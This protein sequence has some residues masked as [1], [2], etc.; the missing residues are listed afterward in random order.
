MDRGAWQATVH[1]VVKSNTT[2]QLRLREHYLNPSQIIALLWRRGLHD[3]HRQ[4]HC[5]DADTCV[6][7][8]QQI[9]LPTL[10]Q[11]R[12]WRTDNQ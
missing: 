11:F 9:C 5:S 8:A 2:E 6:A 12:G 1:G 10:S 4:E 7:E 3:Q